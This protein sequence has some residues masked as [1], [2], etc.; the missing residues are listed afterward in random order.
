MSPTMHPEARDNETEDFG[1]RVTVFNEI[2]G[3]T[4]DLLFSA[5]PIRIGR[6]KLNELVLN[7]PYVSQ[8]QAVI[9]F[10]R[11]TLS[12]TQVGST[13]SIV[14]G[15]RKLRPNEEAQ[16]SGQEKIRIVPFDIYLQLVAVPRPQAPKP[17]PPAAELS[18]VS[19]QYSLEQAALR[20]LDGLSSQFLGLRLQ[21]AQEIAAF[22]ARLE[23]TLSVFLRFFVA[24]QKGQEQ[25]RQALD[26]KVLDSAGRN[27]VERVQD[28]TE[29]AATLLAPAHVEAIRALE[30]AFK[31]IMIHQVALLN[32]LMAGVRTLLAKLSPKT[33]TKEAAKEHRSPNVKILW[34][35]F[36]RMH[37]DLAEEDNETFETIF[38]AQFGKAYAALVGKKAE[39]QE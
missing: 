19:A 24:L 30:T 23:E 22:S 20:A 33:V 8:W 29:L 12:I 34:Q 31:N 16:L 18:V 11:R 36:E 4:T 14:V 6:N 13:N 17:P 21:S 2:D 9:G 15:D 10:A 3:T 38:G 5:F 37:R 35:T 32:G 27:P 1:L 28:A 39:D 26:L 25:F 7:H